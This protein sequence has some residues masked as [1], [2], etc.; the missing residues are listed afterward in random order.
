[1]PQATTRVRVSFADVDISQRIHF[2]SWFRYMEVAEHALMRSLGIPYSSTLMDAA[3]PRVHLE[4]DFRGAIHYDDLLDVEARIER[5]GTASWTVVFTGWHV[6]H[7]V[8]SAERG[9][10]VATGRMTIVAMDPQTERSTPL[11]EWLRRVLRGED[12]DVTT[13][14]AAGAESGAVSGDPA[15][16]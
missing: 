15:S 6:G 10:V 3:L 14:G 5:V 2:T 12:G 7:G 4:A 9:E 1:M 8:P 16:E 13:P 11:P